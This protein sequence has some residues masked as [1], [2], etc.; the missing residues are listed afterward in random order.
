M[1]RTGRAQP[2]AP[3]SGTIATPF[4]RGV[5][6]SSQIDLLRARRFMP[7]F[8]VQATSAIND[9]LF[10]SSFIMLVTFG[11]TMRTALD[12]GVLSAI[13]GGLLIAPYFLVLGAG[14]RAGRPLRA[15]PPAAHP[16][17]RRTGDRAGRRRRVARR[18]YGAVVCRAV[19]ARRPGDVFEPG[20][21]RAAA[22]A[23]ERRRAGRRQRAAR[24][25]H[26]SGDS[27]RDDRRR[28]RRRARPWHRGGLS[29]AGPVRGFAASPR[30]LAYRAPRPRR[31]SCA[32]AATRSPR[33]PRS[34]G[35][36]G[37]AA[38]SSCR[39]SAPRGSGWSARCS[40]RRSRPSRRRRWGP[41]PAS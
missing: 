1:Q 16:E 19:P 13:A 17:S 20:A 37:N 41:A 25:R 9:N 35:R 40:C 30:A 22:A 2:A 31:P 3:R 29:A 15:R 36:P 24:R 32:S 8:A 38:R 18:Q 21:L 14:R 7:L 6:V 5:H 34:C 4:R 39:S 12:P 23:S 33:P 27:V 11:V 26:V 10:K 28:Y